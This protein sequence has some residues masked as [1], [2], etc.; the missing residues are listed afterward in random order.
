MSYELDR[1]E[2]ECPCPCGKGRIVYGSGSNDWNQ[3]RE[4]MSEI[5]CGECAKKYRLAGNGLLPIDFPEYSGDEQV[6]EKMQALEHVV[7]NYD[8]SRGF[9]YWPEEVRRKRLSAYLTDEERDRVKKERDRYPLYIALTYAKELCGQ[10]SEEV[11]LDVNMQ[12][13]NAKFSTQL[14]GVAKEIAERHKRFFNTIKI[15]KVK[16][17]VQVAL[18]NYQKYQEADLEDQ[19]YLSEL[20]K[21][22]DGYKKEYY[23]DYPAYRAKREEAFIPLYLKDVE[24]A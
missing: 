5:W 17:P 22:L 1:V 6:K 19:Q 8:G 13:I 10:Y 2:K 18:R 20:K 15:E 11:L 16:Y 4:G 12:L 23:K 7:S 3:V 24:D 21:E 14:T 9:K